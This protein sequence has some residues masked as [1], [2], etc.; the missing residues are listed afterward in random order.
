MKRTAKHVWVPAAV[1]VIF[2]IVAL[3][4]VE[5]LGCR[6]RGLVASI[7]AIAAG[8]AGIIA[9]AKALRGK[10]RG[11]PKSPWWMASALIFSIPLFYIVF[12]AT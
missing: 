12:V 6:N 9:A 7:I 8:I 5:I 3:Q 10:I 4:P 11:E 1:A 2:F